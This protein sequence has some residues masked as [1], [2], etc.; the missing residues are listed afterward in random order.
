MIPQHRINGWALEHDRSVRD[1]VR[2]TAI[3]YKELYRDKFP[4]ELAVAGENWF[5]IA[6]LKYV[7][8]RPAAAAGSVS[9]DWPSAFTINPK[10]AVVTA[11]YIPLGKILDDFDADL[12]TDETALFPLTGLRCDEANTLGRREQERDDWYTVRRT[13]GKTIKVFPITPHFETVYLGQL[14]GGSNVGYTPIDRKPPID[15]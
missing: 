14:K 8:N 9:L 2:M 12:T 7:G 6:E 11:H 1:L 15:I 13:N 3:M 10:R 5:Y 4:P